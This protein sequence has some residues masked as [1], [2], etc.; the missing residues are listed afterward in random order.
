MPW[1][2]KSTSS[3]REAEPSLPRVRQ[4]TTDRT[5][6]TLVGFEQSRFIPDSTQT[7]PECVLGDEGPV[8]IKKPLA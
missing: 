7:D 8:A 2:I 6:L 4:S 5:N 3:I 1:V